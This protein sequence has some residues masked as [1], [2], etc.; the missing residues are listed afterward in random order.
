MRSSNKPC[1]FPDCH[2]KAKAHGLCSGHLDQ[3]A[4]GQPLKPIKRH[5][6][7]CE[8][9]N[10][11]HRHFANGLCRGHRAQQRKGE[12]LAPLGQRGGR[13]VDPKGYVWVKAPEG[14]PNAKSRKGW[15]AEHVLVMSEILGRPLREGETVH[16][17]NLIRADNRPENLELWTSHQP[18]GTSVADMLAWCRWFIGQYDDAPEWTAKEGGPLAKNEVGSATQRSEA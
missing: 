5:R 12:P 15:I 1:G 3:L 7:G 4:R 11:D 17:R 2:G 13:W 8:F 18:R 10:C 9:P 14:H 6:T 16:H